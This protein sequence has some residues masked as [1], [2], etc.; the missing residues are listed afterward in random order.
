VKQALDEC[1]ILLKFLPAHSSDQVQ[2]LDLGIFSTFK[3]MYMKRLALV[4]TSQQTG[5]IIRMCDAWREAALPR[6]IVSAFRRAGLVPIASAGTFYLAVDR[7]EADK[8]RHWRNALFVE[9]HRMR[10][11]GRESLKK[12]FKQLFRG[13]FLVL[14]ASA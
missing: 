12:L 8:V 2:P 14:A 4:V 13:L 10:D 5:Q 3:R 1:H 11:G 6:N 7:T 9:Q